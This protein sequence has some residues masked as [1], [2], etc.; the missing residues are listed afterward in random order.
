MVRLE[1]GFGL[2]DE[3]RRN[4]KKIS[5]Q[6]NEEQKDGNR[7]HLD[8]HRSSQTNDHLSTDH[9]AR[10]HE[11]PG[12]AEHL[13]ELSELQGGV[14]LVPHADDL[15]RSRVG[16]LRGGGED[17]GEVTLDGRERGGERRGGG[18]GMRRPGE[19]GSQDG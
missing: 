4:N 2:G 13:E 8:D 15:G 9:L 6:R 17:V 18:A 5:A 10:D 11:A 16:E 3:E 1:E 7:T 12:L 14:L 19:G